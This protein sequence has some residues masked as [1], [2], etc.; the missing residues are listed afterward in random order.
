MSDILLKDAKI[1]NRFFTSVSSYI[2]AFVFGIGLV[3]LQTDLLQ[4]ENW[5]FYLFL[6]FV[7]LSWFAVYLRPL[8]FLALGFFYA[9]FA[10]DNY[11]A[12]RLDKKFTHQDAELVGIVCG[13]PGKSAKR[14]SFYLNVIKAKSAATALPVKKIKLNWYGK[15]YDLHPGQI[16]SLT[17]R[18]K[19][20]RGFKN[21]TGFD[22]GRWLLQTGV[23]ATGYVKA[24]LPVAII[25]H[26]ARFIDKLHKVRF[27]LKREIKNKV[28]K[29]NLA[30][31]FLALLIGDRSEISQKQWQTLQTTGTAHLLAISGLHL[32]LV[33]GAAFYLLSFALSFVRLN[34]I[35]L[36]ILKLASFGAVSAGGAYALMAGLA[37]PTQRALIMLAT[38][39]V[40]IML[41]HRV[42]MFSGLL[43]AM[44]FCLLLEPF[45]ILSASFWLSFSAV[46]WIMVVIKFHA[47]GNKYLLLI[48]IQLVLALGLLP[49]L[50]SFNLPV[51][52]VGVLAN[53]FVL[54]IISFIGLPLLLLALITIDTFI[55][56]WL[57]KFAEY[58]FTII[59]QILEFLQAF[60]TPIFNMPTAGV[61]LTALLLIGILLNLLP[62]GLPGKYAG[63]VLLGTLLFFAPD[64]PNLGE[65]RISILDVGQGQAVL[66]ETKGH[67]MLYD[68]GPQ[69]GLNGNAVGRIIKPLLQAKSIKFLDKVMLSH[70][71]TDHAAGIHELVEKITIGNIMAPIV[72]PKLDNFLC[73]KDQKWQWDDVTFEVLHPRESTNFSGNDASCVL[74]I[75]TGASSVLLT[76]DIGKKVEQNL[77]IHGLQQANVL[78]LA[79]HGSKT[80]STGIFLDKVKPDYAIVS[81]GYKNQYRFPHKS[82]V[83]RVRERKIKLFNTANDGAVEVLLS[84]NRVRVRGLRDKNKRLWD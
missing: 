38:G 54:P 69:Y 47:T 19:T 74:R 28:Q 16:I 18:I 81:S 27:E 33:A 51:S 31:L 55:S 78:A 7:I 36:N 8:V 66:I 14:L 5:L 26:S 64:R 50:N 37:I 21:A 41:K 3:F 63:L 68:T 83:G 46:F 42:S 39:L 2:L 22:Y 73:H 34:F 25:G 48:K 53:I 32:G 43:W 65:A 70:F 58:V 30:A 17:A 9:W 56:S 57:F 60:N 80:S 62:R 24:K 45:A 11:F 29:Q 6:L 35:R 77:V 59:W 67:N 82:V 75:S 40:L 13:I 76:G 79:H 15:Y 72:K 61:F 44:L 84:K 52:S 12:S 71:D 49:I 1:S 10:V 4:L 20:P 23:D